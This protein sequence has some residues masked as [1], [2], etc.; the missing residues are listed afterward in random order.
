MKS[1]QKAVVKMYGTPSQKTYQSQ[2]PLNQNMYQN[3]PND[4]VDWACLAQ[5]WIQMK[6]TVPATE[7][8]PPPIL[9]NKD[10]EEKGEA[11]MEVEKDEED[12][13]PLNMPTNNHSSTNWN[14]STWTTELHDSNQWRNLNSWN[15]WQNSVNTNSPPTL[16]VVVPEI[17]SNPISNINLYKPPVANSGY[18]TA[19]GVASTNK[20]TPLMSIMIKNDIHTKDNLPNLVQEDMKIDDDN[21]EEDTTQT[22]DAAKRKILPAWIR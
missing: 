8:P 14:N 3:M 18:W 4:R 1:E 5:Q 20:I 6:E 11:P 12:I 17:T 15:T 19:A 16:P 21:E 13:P 7:C 10:F 9:S 22:I 2:W